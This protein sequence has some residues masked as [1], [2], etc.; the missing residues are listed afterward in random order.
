MKEIKLTKNQVALIDDADFDVLSKQ[1]WSAHQRARHYGYY[2]IGTMK[3]GKSVLMHRFILD[4]K[5]PNMVV[6]HI[7]GNGLNNQRG[8][9]RICTRSQNSKNSRSRVGSSS[10][11]LGVN[12]RYNGRFQ[13]HI[14]V[15][16][17]IKCL[18]TFINE[19]DAA[20]AYDRA[21]VEYNGQFAS[22]NIKA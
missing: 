5:D 1:K 18:G 7:D 4:V 12:K 2:A 19:I 16:G 3:S 13:A 21:A 6:D 8:N 15:G 9:I 10:R 17:K 20:K 11:Y 22:V 14:R